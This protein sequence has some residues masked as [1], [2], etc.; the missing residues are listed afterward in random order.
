MSAAIRS[1]GLARAERTRYDEALATFMSEASRSKLWTAVDDVLSHGPL[2]VEPSKTTGL[3]L[4]YVQSGKTTN[5][6]GLA[7]A[8]ADAG[9][10]IIV[11][12]LGSTNLL[13]DQNGKRIRDALIEDRWDYKWQEVKGLKGTSGAQK[14]TAELARGRVLLIPT[15]KHAGRIR[16]LASA[17]GKS[18]LSSTPV[19]VIDD[20]ADQ[21]SLNTAV[22]QGAESSTYTAISELRAALGPHMYVQY[23]ATPYAP[24]LLDL[25]DHLLPEFV[26][27]LHP[28]PGYT[29]GREFFV[30]HA[31]TVIRPIPTSDEQVS[32]VLPQ[33]LPGSLE[34]ALAN[35][36]IG[37][38]ALLWRDEQLEPVSLLVHSTQRNDAQ[39]R[40][41]FLIQRRLKKWQASVDTALRFD[42]L[43][44]LLRDEY[45]HLKA[46]GARLPDRDHL[47]PHLRRA[48]RETTTWLVN[49]ASAVKAIQWNASPVHILVGGNK[50]DRGFTVEGLTVTYMNRPASG[51]VDT[52]EQR[53]RAF[54]YRGE[55]LP[56]CQFFATPRTLKILRET[57]FT[58]YDL[59]ARLRDAL[60]QGGSVDDWARDIGLLLPTGTQPTR[61]AVIGALNQFNTSGD[62]WHSLRQPSLEPADCSANLEL[63]NSI[64][65]LDAARRNYGR[66]DFR[67]VEVPLQMLLDDL[68][69]PWRLGTYSAGWRHEDIIDHL[70]RMDGNPGIPVLLMDDQNDGP[71]SRKWDE[72]GFVNLFQGRDGSGTPD[73]YPG[74]RAIPPSG[75]S[76]VALQ[77]H[78]AMPRGTQTTVH[79]LAIRLT[80]M[81]IARKAL[82]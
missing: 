50:L 51:Q 6:I 30:D 70:A 65:L 24:L 75:T 61:P 82:A 56:Y 28:G 23:T 20:E 45:K 77:V 62:G 21:A 72:L 31:D 26:T 37:A 67:T 25:N 27:L 8:A 36:L 73:G 9:Y 59:R 46:A 42:D 54:G 71:R 1:S 81:Q 38:A 80:D 78:H 34:T 22:K 3:A 19:L 63:V 5:I 4:G 10:R 57:V 14:V 41:H 39:D 60:D 13:V 74:D 69:R 44:A 18:N 55:L 29:G 66:L 7:A 12:L 58:E 47:L 76:P 15:I 49:S 2:G 17:L 79:T 68:L 11:S 53:A 33:R 40:Y 43:E 48:V 35:F 16:D 52:M 64:G 32:K